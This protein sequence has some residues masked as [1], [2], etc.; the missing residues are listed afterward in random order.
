M[1][2]YLLLTFLENLAGEKLALEA[3]VR[4]A[5]EAA[6]EAVGAASAPEDSAA[7]GPEE[8][9]DA[10]PPEVMA[11]EPEGPRPL[12]RPLPLQREDGLEGVVWGVGR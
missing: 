9:E 12:S 6:T 2:L 5:A 4:C 8:E 1:I 3:A 11:N 7:F 10:A